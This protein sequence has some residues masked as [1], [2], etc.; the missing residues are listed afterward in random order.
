M[1]TPAPVDTLARS[2][3]PPS[4]PA[5]P[6]HRIAGLDALRGLAALSVLIGHYT[7]GY[8]RLYGHSDDLLF[9]YPWPG[10]GVTL[11]F[12]I[13][14]FVIL[15]TAE[16]VKGPLDFAWARFSRLYPAYWAAVILTF[17][18]VTIFSL[19]GRQPTLPRAVVNLTM[20]QKLIG[21]GSVDGVYWTLFVELCFY[22]IVFALLCIRGVRC[23]EFVLL[24]LVALSALDHLLVY[25]VKAGW[26]QA[27]RGVLILEHAYAFAIGVLFYRSLKSPRAWH[28]LAI[29][30]C[31]AYSFAFDPRRDFY[32]AAGLAA[33]MFV[34]T[35][36]W[37]PFLSWRPLVFLGTISYSLYLTHQNIG[38]VVIRGGYK[39]GLG[40]NVSILIATA[41]ALLMAVAITFLIERPAMEYLRNR[42]PA[43]LG[44]PAPAPT[45]HPTRPAPLA[46]AA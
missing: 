35:R 2:T 27:L 40:P 26:L 11:F 13:S 1:M 9:T 28:A 39:A 17:T 15:M 19:P 4:I 25:H 44:G 33:L 32:F 46:A 8:D 30:A 18:V 21:V 38:Y 31:L 6:K 45:P 29:A 12:M 24:G 3:A 14:G 20:L 5:S 41:V 16:R 43:W 7:A 10:Y 22:A 23:A 37:L 36:G 42:R 34:T